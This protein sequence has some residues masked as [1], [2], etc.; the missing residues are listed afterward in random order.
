[1]NDAFV[2]LDSLNETKIELGLDRIKKVL[3][4]LGNI[5]D[6]LKIIHVAGT[7]GKGSTSSLINNILI[8]NL[9]QESTKKNIGLF[10]SP[11]ITKINER[12]KI[13]NE[14]IS[15]DDLEKY[16]N[17]F[18]IL[19]EKHDIHLTYFEFLTVI[20]IK[21]FWDNDVLISVFEC[22][23]GGRLDST[24]VFAKPLVTVIT[25]IDF[26]HT[27]YLGNTLSSILHEKM[28][29]LRADIPVVSAI[30]QIELQKII[31]KKSKDLNS[32]LFL[33]NRDFFVKPKA[34]SFVFEYLD[35]ELD[36]IKLKIF[37]EHQYFNLSVALMV[38][39]IL[40]E[41]YGYK[42][43][44]DKEV[45]KTVNNFIFSGRLEFIRFD[46]NEF[47]TNFILDVGHNLAGIK[48]CV[49]YLQTIKK[50]Y[51]NIVIVF[52]MLQDK[53]YASCVSEI[54]KVGDFF[55]LTSPNSKRALKISD[56][57]KEFAGHKQS[58][59][60]KLSSENYY[61]ILQNISKN[62]GQNDLICVVGSFYLKIPLL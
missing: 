54:L 35:Y 8:D 56:I 3:D 15:D 49:K 43:N 20:A 52:G 34:N 41:K 31:T 4:I 6:D 36:E 46:K 33:I 61:E 59:K 42:F 37:G 38:F 62:F 16:I 7:N 53:D 22:G 57:L 10:T 58:K 9:L 48:T 12:I 11:H 27:E 1:M 23:L 32:D 51:E 13:N 47:G 19:L 50:D 17:Y 14:D 55:Y 26:D 40:R 18:K 39:Y 24:N 29:I 5:Q 45:R 44:P 60:V 2:Y 21:Y 30:S 25:N 28:G